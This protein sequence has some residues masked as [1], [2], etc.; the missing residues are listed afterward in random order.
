MNKTYFVLCLVITSFFSLNAQ[1]KQEIRGII[2]DEFNEPIPFVAV[3]IVEKYIGS[4]STEDGEFSFFITE[5]ELQDSLSISSLGYDPFK[6]KVADFL[7][8]EKKAIVL[9]ETVTEL[10]EVK[11]L[12]P[13]NYVV[14]ALKKLKENTISTTHQLEFLFRTAVTEGDKAK[15]LVENYIKVRDRGPAYYFGDVQVAE[16]R[17]SADYRIWKPKHNWHQIN[18]VAHVNPI[19]P[20]DSGHARN[21]KKFIWK[22]IGDSSYEGEDVV[23]LEGQNPKKKWERIK[24]FIGVDSFKIYRIERGSS[25]FVYKKYKNGKLVLNYYK[26]D[27]H[28]SKDRIPKEYWNTP[29]INSHFKGEAFLY[30]VITN[31]KDIKVVP[32]GINVD[33]HLIDLPYNPSFW[34]NLSLPPDTK[35]YKSIRE[36]L[37]A[38][39]G[40]PLEKQ[41]ELVNKK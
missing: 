14:T 12:V 1:Q 37:E 28:L 19:R 4:A 36:G 33:A 3:G 23:I 35:F 18:V 13:N 6:I 34:D 26:H 25:L 29:V 32:Y 39:Y 31:K 10:N 38:A 5:N 41:Y 7:K 40:V 17:K 20:N 22:K 16:S 27:W 21:I 30:N 15:L 11:L 2:L 24:L 9:K 8:L